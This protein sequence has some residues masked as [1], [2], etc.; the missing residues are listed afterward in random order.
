[1][2]HRRDVL[3][4]FVTFFAALGSALATPAAAAVS[5]A[6]A[7]AKP[8]GGQLGLAVAFTPE[9]QLQAAV[10]A[11]EPC[12]L[13]R[14]AIIKVPEDAARA[15]SSAKLRIVRIGDDRHAIVVEIPEPAAQRTWAAVLAGPLSGAAPVVPFSGYTGLV[16]GNE[17]ERS[18]PMLLVR[19]GVVYVGRQQAGY[20]LCGRPAILAPEVLD[21]KTLTLKAAKVQRLDEAEME[22]A[23]VLDAK[24]VTPASDAKP[25]AAPDAKGA[26]APEPKPEAAA[27]A[28][29]LLHARWAT[30]AARS[31]PA[32]ALTDGK[33]ETAW[34]EGRGGAGRGEL[35]VV[36]AP[37]EVAI[38]G[39]EIALADRRAPHAAA[40][41]DVWLVTDARAFHVRLPESKAT[42]PSRYEV[43][44]PAPVSTSCVAL[45]LDGASSED[46][47]A[48]VGV[49]ELAARPSSAASLDELV[50]ALGSGG[51][52]AE[53]AGAV[54]RASGDEAMTRVAAAFPSLDEN[55]KRVA[56]DVLD[57]A[58]CAVATP[59]YVSALVGTYEAQRL[60][61][62][63]ALERCPNDAAR[64]F[65][66]AIASGSL[67]ER[68]AL[69]DE[70]AS[71]A[72]EA[73]I[74]VLVPRL[75][76]AGVA[77]RRAYRA[78]IGRAALTDGA[79]TNVVAAL[80][81]TD[82][83]TVVTLDLLRALGSTV[84]RYGDSARRA[85]Y[86]LLTPQAT[87]RT[88]YLMLEPATE[89]ASIDPA[90]RAYV[91]R[92]L[93]AEPD[94]RIRAHAALSLRD[95]SPYHVHLSRLLE[96]D[97]VRVRE[98]AVTALGEARADD[99]RDRMIY[100]MENDPWPF[101]RIAAAHAIA[102]LPAG[103][104]VDNALA[105]LLE[106]DS[107]PDVRRAALR[108]IGDRRAVADMGV[109]RD[110]FSD[111]EELPGVRAEAALSL[112][113]LCDQESLGA[114]T[115]YSHKLASPNADE[116][117]RLMGKSA[118]TALALIHPKDLERRLAPLR[119]KSSPAAVRLFALTA[120]HTAPRCPLPHPPAR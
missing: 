3:G 112:G 30:S 117:D 32:S 81:R 120:L 75:A 114:L 64:A 56:L 52:E 93:T 34:A 61:A 97:A 90:A 101:V 29:Q 41:R 10:C 105:R 118:L 51:Q 79:R 78:A 115:E 8:G 28:T 42:E 59:V 63:R 57:E 76:K 87:F 24:P 71:I 21:P 2:L 91:E 27:P 48:N 111:E 119:D 18:G 72:P 65:E 113:L 1:V 39:F 11:T 36:S 5:S 33:L 92:A 86:R 49:A 74:A 116:G 20:D 7:V 25:A 95:A 15:A 69:A 99:T 9:G 45:V 37:R 16:E 35:V 104:A 38:G 43:S 6:T 44:L 50:R 23:P 88:R 4:P 85:F 109:V 102:A 58:P 94:P 108:A 46:P 106:N 55:G 103:P 17:D 12:T 53:A 96:D 26:P 19:E 62:R 47:E 66:A 82:A 110:R 100:L 54:L 80:E 67:P 73:T 14:A 40:P 89:L 22:A 60:H 31:A 83:P 70:L 68:V 13:D 107:S 84:S 77:E 98:A